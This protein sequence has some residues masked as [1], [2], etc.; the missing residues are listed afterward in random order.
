M[1]NIK[2]I[3]FD[4][5]NTLI[6]V[7][8]QNHFF[9]KLFKLS[10]RS[11]DIELPSYLKLVMTKNIEELIT[12]L[13]VEFEGLFSKNHTILEQELDSIIVYK[14]VYEVLESLKQ[15][16]RVFLISNL[17]SPYKQP[18]FEKNL[19]EYFEEM[20]FSCDYGILKPNQEIFREVERLTKNKGDEIL[21]IGDSFKSDIVGAK[22]MNWNYLQINR[23][24]HSGKEYE[25]RNL[26]EIKVHL[27]NYL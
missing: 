27:E 14:E 23:Q 4:L 6:E 16:F 2:V 18:V 12:I 7:K 1:N 24:K 19:A 21:M 11:F 10:A 17:A 22:N 20:I 26:N 15:E 8:E 9:L 3:V 13:P 25:I 5:Y